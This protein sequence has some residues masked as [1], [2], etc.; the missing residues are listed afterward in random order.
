MSHMSHCTNQQ[1]KNWSKSIVFPRLQKGRQA[2]FGLDFWRRSGL[3]G[4]CVSLSGGVRFQLRE[5]EQQQ[6]QEQQEGS[7]SHCTNNGIKTCFP[8]PLYNQWYKNWSKTIV[9]LG[10]QKGRQGVFGLDFWRC[11]VLQGHCVSPSG[12]VRFEHREEEQQQQQEQQEGSVSHCTN[13]AI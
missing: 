3:Q 13:N 1:Y 9:F 5:E 8:V 2:V 4:H 10:F 7:M 11:S 6:Q 12:R